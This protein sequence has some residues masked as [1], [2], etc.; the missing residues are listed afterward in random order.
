MVKLEDRRVVL[1]L[2]DE[3]GRVLRQAGIDV[4]DTGDH[5]LWVRIDY[6]DGQH[7]ILVRWDYNL[8]IDIGGGEIR[9]EGRVDRVN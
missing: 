9:T 4:L 5:G 3:G 1:Y 6:E 2:G 7:V 8:A